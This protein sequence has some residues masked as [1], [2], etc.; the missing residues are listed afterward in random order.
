MLML[1]IVILTLML[2]CSLVSDFIDCMSAANRSLSLHSVYIYIL[3]Y[4]T[5]ISLNYAI[6]QPVCTNQKKIQLII[7][8]FTLNKTAPPLCA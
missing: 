7:L 1:L 2:E 4:A 3:L 5:I 8:N 6:I